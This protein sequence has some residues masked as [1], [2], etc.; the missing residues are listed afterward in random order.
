[1]GLLHGL[2][3]A[4]HALVVLAIT[5][6]EVVVIG[7]VA[8]LVIYLGYNAY[9]TMR[10]K[11]WLQVKAQYPNCAADAARGMEPD[12]L[13]SDA[14]STDTMEPGEVPIKSLE[15]QGVVAGKNPSVTKPAAPQSIARESAETAAAANTVNH[16]ADHYNSAAAIPHRSLA[17][18][19]SVTHNGV[20][21]HAVTH[22]H[23]GP[24]HGKKKY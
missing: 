5:I 19:H 8:Y 4:G 15:A 18:H 7:L 22:H 11:T 23:S 16:S 13:P 12:R 20:P 2:R 6:I 10:Q 21:Q 14:A 3:S 9:R 24:Q 1:M 17:H